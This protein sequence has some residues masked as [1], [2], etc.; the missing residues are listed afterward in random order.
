MSSDAGLFE[1]LKGL[2]RELHHSAD[3]ERWQLLLHPDFFEYGRSG[4]GFDREKALALLLRNDASPRV[5][6][7][8]FAIQPL[9]PGVVLMTYR[10]A[11]I[12]PD[13]SLERYSNR[14]SIWLETPQGW[15]M[16]FH[17]G[18]ATMPFAMS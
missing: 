12:Q 5:H 10:S 17:Q 7:Q 14:S 6:A 4:L 9:A 13:G 16:R 2:E 3:P 18:T 1:I 11:H 8:D 15:Q